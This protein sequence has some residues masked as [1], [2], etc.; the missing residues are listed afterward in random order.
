MPVYHGY[1]PRVGRCPL[2]EVTKEDP[3][4]LTFH[5]TKDPLVPPTSAI[6]LRGFLARTLSK[7]V[8][9]FDRHLETVCGEGTAR[10]RA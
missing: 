7:S 2:T 6:R 8:A 5:G 9:F 10:V 4:I 1:L 3:P